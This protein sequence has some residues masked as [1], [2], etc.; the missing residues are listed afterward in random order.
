MKIP[1]S[2][3]PFESLLSGLTPEKFARMT[4]ASSSDSRRYLHWDQVRYRSPP[5]DLTREEWWVGLKLSRMSTRRPLPLLDSDGRRFTYSLPG[6]ALELTHKVDQRASGQI[7][8]SEVVTNPSTRD[9]YLVNSLIEEAITSSQLEGASTSRGVAKEM[10][11]SG[12][13]PRNHSEQ[14]ILNNYMAMN[15]V[16]ERQR[17]KLSP[18]LVCEL[19][20]I[21]T[22]NTLEDPDAAGRLQQLGEERVNVYDN[23]GQLLHVPPPADQLPQRL[24]MLCDFANGETPEGFLHPVVRAIVVHFWLGYDHPFVDGNGRTARA[25]FYWSML[26]Q[27]YWLAEY[28]TISKIL[29]N[30]PT[31]YARSFLYAESD[32]NDAT[33]FILYQ[34]GIVVRAIA[35]LNEYL[36]RKMAEVSE[37]EQ[38]LKWS[39]LNNRQ[40]A[41]LSHA[42]RHHDAA[43]TYRSH[44]G[45]HRVVHQTARTDL[46]E[47][48]EL[49][50]LDKRMRGKVHTF[51]PALDLVEALKASG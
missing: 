37:V 8:I 29:R 43:Y 48:A 25:L 49:G 27:G 17:D 4:E 23:Q 2:P 19:H 3:P 28:L 1:L 18:E 16:R 38:L 7:Q 20:R 39:S 42:L 30:A 35:D 24:Q 47:L 46:L 10:I 14:M 41:L 9:R 40:I 50:F 26:N 31:K 22:D 36:R 44:A 6:L 15:Y 13:K 51:Y 12:R 34:L 21:V 5:D 33:Y 32:D 11:R 45:S